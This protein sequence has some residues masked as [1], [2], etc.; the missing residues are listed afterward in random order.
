MLNSLIRVCY[1]GLSVCILLVSASTLRDVEYS[2]DHYCHSEGCTEAGR[3][4]TSKLDRSV[5]PCEDIFQ[6]SC[7]GWFKDNPIS[8]EWNEKS[9]LIDVS[10]QIDE[11]LLELIRQD[12][13]EFKGTPSSA[14]KKLKE[15]Y[16]SCVDMGA[17]DEKGAEPLKQLID[18]F[19][20]WTVTETEK[21]WEKDKWDLQEAIFKTH[22]WWGSSF[23]DIGVSADEKNGSRNIVSMSQGGIA[24]SELPESYTEESTK[25]F[26]MKAAVKLGEL[27]GGSSVNVTAKMAK[28]YDL[29]KNLAQIFVPKENLTNPFNA[30]NLMTLEDFQKLIG[31][32]I[33]MEKFME[34]VFPELD[35]RDEDELVVIT[36]E[37]FKEL[38]NVVQD[39]DK[40]TLANYIMWNLILPT[41]GYLPEEFE[42]VNIKQATESEDKAEIPLSRQT[43]CLQKA[44]KV[45]PFAASA[46]YIDL[47]FSQETN[48]K[49]VIAID[50]IEHE[51]INN[52]DELHWIDQ[53][54]KQNLREKAESMTNQIGFPDWILNPSKL[55]AYYDSLV[56]NPDDFWGNFINANQFQSNQILESYQKPPDKRKWDTSPLEVNAFY[57]STENQM[58]VLAG[59]LHEDI[60]SPYYP[61]S[62]VYGKLGS[63]IGHE[64]IHGFDNSGR[65][66][67]KDGH[68]Q[69]SWTPHVA[70]EF[71]Q[72]AQCFIDQY[73][74]YLVYNHSLSGSQTLGENIADNG[75]MRL[76]YRAYKNS[77]KPELR[78]PG[79]NLTDDQLFFV[80]MSHFHCGLF[81]EDSALFR[82]RTDTHAISEF[83][84]IGTMSNSR[85]FAEAFNCPV[86]SPM[87]PEE[88]CEI[89]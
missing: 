71:D 48:V 25:D 41:V 17:I 10:L 63:I 38:Q 43:S 79:L 36:P 5:D 73:D 7:G 68:L 24:L 87:N 18:D 57:Y 28:V 14:I 26:F 19:G 60:V 30:Y 72:R 6:F 37:Y 69:D 9:P 16:W 55:D 76:A 45:M 56:V 67:D 51:F 33:N 58:V 86:G 80:G 85:D 88:K 23:F 31:S 50:D 77:I 12:G 52:L 4:I 78:L 27:L 54:T 84:V 40:E 15:F 34:S 21:P 59:I 65:L 44:V 75:G 29:E 42:D 1:I 81:S 61:T 49:V 13:W 39:T 3:S 66:Y 82:L 11:R 74:S 22:A 62:Y 2:D 64:I 70:E 32:W 20:S 47:F 46:L 89:W 83:R 8:E 53:V 35:W